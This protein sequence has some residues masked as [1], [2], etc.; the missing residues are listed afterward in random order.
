MSVLTDGYNCENKNVHVRGEESKLITRHRERQM[1]HKLPPN[2][3]GGQGRKLT[4]LAMLGEQNIRYQRTKLERRRART[5][6]GAWN[7]GT[8]VT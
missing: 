7:L 1:L 2:L 8:G 5:A 3:C 4:G 6:Q